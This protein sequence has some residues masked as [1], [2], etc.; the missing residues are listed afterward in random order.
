VL[1]LL[2]K[3]CPVLE[4][5]QGVKMS[6]RRLRY[7]REYVIG[8]TMFSSHNRLFKLPPSLKLNIVYVR[9]AKQL[10]LS[11]DSSKVGLPIPQKCTQV[12]ES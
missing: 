3:Y 7:H 6:D 4:R 9:L 5:I 11:K 2:L 1:S 10:Y 12:E 8:E